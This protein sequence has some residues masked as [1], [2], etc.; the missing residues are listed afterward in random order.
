VANHDAHL[1]GDD[2]LAA[3]KS[4]WGG[5]KGTGMGMGMGM[6]TGTGTGKGKGNV[7]DGVGKGWAMLSAAWFA[8][9]GQARPLMLG[10][11]GQR[12]LDSKGHAHVSR[13]SISICRH[14]R[15]R[16]IMTPED[17]LVAGMPR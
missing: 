9:P 15:T 11:R 4:G 16:T 2:Q 17:E 10:G 1:V 13:R 6:G 3:T 5:G 7:G 12:H 14:T 8:A